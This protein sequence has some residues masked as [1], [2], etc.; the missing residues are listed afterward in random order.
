MTDPNIENG[1]KLEELEAMGIS[2]DTLWK[3]MVCWLGAWE[4]GEFLDDF[5]NLYV[6]G[7][8]EAEETDSWNE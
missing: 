6:D 3:E 5:Y 7:E 8:L 1:Y 2:T 4:L